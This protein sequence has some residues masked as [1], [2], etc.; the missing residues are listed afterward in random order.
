MC[1]KIYTYTCPTTRKDV[2]T[3][4]IPPSAEFGEIFIYMYRLPSLRASPPP[5]DEASQSR[6]IVHYQWIC[7]PAC[8]LK[9]LR[10]YDVAPTE[11][12]RLLVMTWNRRSVKTSGILCAEWQILYHAHHLARCRRRN[13]MKKMGSFSIFFTSTMAI[14]WQYCFFGELEIFEKGQGRLFSIGHNTPMCFQ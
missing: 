1:H 8:N 3:P 13:V 5:A 4:L 2:K 11:G 7:I 9:S 14:L 10:D 6:L 12:S